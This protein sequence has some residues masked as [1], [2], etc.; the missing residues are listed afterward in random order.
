MMDDLKLS[1][2]GYLQHQVHFGISEG[3]LGERYIIDIVKKD[4]FKTYLDWLD[5]KINSIS[6]YLKQS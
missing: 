1:E 2:T 5:T 3:S 4:S 6:E